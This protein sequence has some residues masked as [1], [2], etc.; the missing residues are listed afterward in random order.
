M[1]IGIPKLIRGIFLNLKQNAK[2]P[3]DI[4]LKSRLMAFNEK[5]FH[6]FDNLLDDSG[7]NNHF[8]YQLHGL[9]PL[10]ITIRNS[11]STDYHVTC[12][13]CPNTRCDLDNDTIHIPTP[14]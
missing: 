12:N 6:S 1:D 11:H 2:K 3:I 14:N 9:Y 10:F 8:F 7:R 4:I 13:A 5:G